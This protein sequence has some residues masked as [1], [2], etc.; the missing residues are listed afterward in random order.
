[1]LASSAMLSRRAPTVAA[2][3]GLVFAAV[4]FGGGPADGS[5][6]FVG[7]AAVLLGCLAIAW[8]RPGAS[9]AGW[10]AIGLAAGL[11]AWMGL[12]ILWSAEPDRSWDYLNRGLVY[13]AF[14]AV[15]LA[16]G[17]VISR[18]DAATGLA[19]VLG[20]VAGWALLGKVVPALGP[21]ARVARLREPVGIWNELALLGDIALPLGLWLATERWWARRLG[22][23]LL[24][25]A[26]TVALALTL[27]RGGILIGVAVLVAYLLLAGPRLDGALALLAAGV[28]AA[29]VAGIAFALP[30]VTS[31][32]EPH[33]VRVSDGV[34]VGVALVVGGALAVGLALLAGRLAVAEGRRRAL[35]RATAVAAAVVVLA[36]VVV[37]GTHASEWWDDFRNPA[38]PGLVND[39]ERLA[40]TSSNNRW[41]WW[42]EAW[43]GW[44]DDPV[45]GNGAG[46]FELIHL[47][48][49]ATNQSVTEPHNV[50]LQLL[51]ETGIVGL[52]LYL[53]A[54]GAA[55]WGGFGR[56]R[57]TLALWLA[58]P[59]YCLHGLLEVDWDFVAV[60]APVFFVAGLLVARS[61]RAAPRVVP[62]LVAA[63]TAFGVLV[64][65]LSPWLA[66]RAVDESYA[67]SDPATALREAKRAH[68]L[69]PLALDPLQAW[70]AAELSRGRLLDAY[71]RTLNEVALQPENPDAWCDAGQFELEALD[72]PFRAYRHL[73]QWYNLDPRGPC[74]G[75][76]DE[77][78]D[79][80]NAG[81]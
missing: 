14:G 73:N 9:A 60:S 55:L 68:A 5:I 38:A 76:L 67:A 61:G 44:K 24:L 59:A 29:V 47:K 37:V 27:S 8:V 40:S 6:S 57:E 22:G 12:S 72:E 34:W 43:R 63:C 25:F 4:F 49:R 64:S 41:A 77:A 20:L 69:N 50:P 51:A 32:G 28:P 11:V 46:T 31:D 15:G 17:V 58:L 16:A 45:L 66:G 36:G 21:D 81:G 52:L 23:T 56:G 3:G 65:L 19:A 71:Q 30:G 80:V 42:T 79:R 26:W 2:V 75:L 70:A 54:F 35:G 62:A 39:P 1:M 74:L 33:S 48:M 10:A 7:G 13:L 18:R 78:R 53:G